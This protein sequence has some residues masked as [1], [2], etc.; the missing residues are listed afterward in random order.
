MDLEDPILSILVGSPVHLTKELQGTSL[1]SAD[2]TVNVD[3]D[4][5]YPGQ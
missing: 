1:R 4:P 3:H 2:F 5:L